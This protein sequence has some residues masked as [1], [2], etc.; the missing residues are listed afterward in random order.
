[1]RSNRFRLRSN[2]FRLDVTGLDIFGVELWK[3]NI[4]GKTHFMFQGATMTFHFMFRGATIINTLAFFFF[5]FFFWEEPWFWEPVD[6]AVGHLIPN[7]VTVS[8]T[9]T[10]ESWWKLL[11]LVIILH[12]SWHQNNRRW[13]FLLSVIIFVSFS[14]TQIIIIIDNFCIALFSGVPKLTARYIL[15]HFLSFTN[16]IHIIMVTNNV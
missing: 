16:I 12:H 13:S 15:Q 1:M 9:Q 3:W 4:I 8:S 10:I 6:S 11:I 14:G 2:K 7:T 5:L